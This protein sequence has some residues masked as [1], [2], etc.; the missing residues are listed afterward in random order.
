MS[1]KEFNLSIKDILNTIALQDHTTKLEC[2]LP[3]SVVKELNLSIK[4]IFNTIALQDHTTKLECNLP[5]SVVKLPHYKIIFP[6]RGISE[7]FYRR[8]VS[9]NFLPTSLAYK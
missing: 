2:N 7:T 9:S 4:D 3:C 6:H 5:C 1:L 8:V